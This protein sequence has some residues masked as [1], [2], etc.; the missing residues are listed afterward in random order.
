MK[1]LIIHPEDTTTN[2]LK[3]IY[4][5]KNWTV[6]NDPY[7][8]RRDLIEYIQNHD[9]IIML[10]HGSPKGLFG[11]FM[12]MIDSDLV[13]LLKQKETI[14]IWC[15]ANVFVEKYKLNS[16]FYTGMFISEEMEAECMDIHDST[17]D[18]I[19]YSNVLFARLMNKY[20]GY[21]IILS[22]V[23]AGYIG[24]DKDDPVIKYNH[25]RMY[26]NRN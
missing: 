8:D 11:A 4:K 23:K 20:I 24:G 10:G 21:K 5:N 15:N 9:R 6:I 17:E 13:W 14:C 16:V 12:M 7:I 25:N 1:T 3:L 19:M 22:L 18:E 2:F 26:G